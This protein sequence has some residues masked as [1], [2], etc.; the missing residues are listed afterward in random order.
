MLQFITHA[1]EKYSITDEVKMVLQ[2]GC[3]WIQ[4]R[5]KD[6]SQDEITEVAKEIQPICKENDCILVVDDWVEVAKELN[7]DGVHLGKTDMNPKEAREI[8]GQQFIIGATA[9]TFEDIEGLSRL[10]IDYIGLGPFRFTSTKQKL[11]PVIGIDGYRDIMS[12]MAEMD[13]KTP[14]VAIGGITYEDINPL[15]ETGLNGI[16]VSG[17]IIGADSPAKETEKMINLLK[18]II[19]ER[20]K[21]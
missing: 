2:G 9:N 1:T 10:D 3:K 12:R 20:N 5:M 4:L 16:A 7:L 19:D 11:S 13:I 14:V 21:R 17:G 18:E 15:M 6:A 8:L